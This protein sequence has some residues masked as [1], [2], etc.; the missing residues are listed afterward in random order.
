MSS[1]PLL[2]EGD[3]NIHVDIPGNED[4]VCLKEVLESM[5]LQQH[6][7]VNEP[8]HKSGHTLDLIITRRWD[9]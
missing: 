5:G 7:H 1:V 2:I 4:C 3:F 8:T 6:V 9:S